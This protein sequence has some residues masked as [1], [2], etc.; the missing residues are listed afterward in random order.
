M[1]SSSTQEAR[2]MTV[3][4]KEKVST[5][6]KE[7][8]QKDVARQDRVKEIQMLEKKLQC[9]Q[10]GSLEKMLL[11]MR[12]DM[13]KDNMCMMEKIGSVTNVTAE[14]Q[15]E[16][17]SLKAEQSSMD[18]QIK[19]TQ[20][21]QEDEKVRVD[22]AEEQVQYLSEQVR[23]LHGLVCKQEQIQE[24]KRND[25]EQERMR[26]MSNNLLI[27]GLDEDD[28]E[29]STATAQLVTDFFSQ[30]MK[31][32]KPI[33]ICSAVCIGKSNSRNVLVKLYKVK[34][35]SDIFEKVSNLKD[36]RNS[37]D[38]KYYMNNH[39]TSVLQDQQRKYRQM[40]RYNALLTGTAKRHLQLKKGEL[41][42]DGHP[43]RPAV[44]APQAGEV[45]YPLD[46]KHVD[47]MKLIKG[48]VQKRGKCTF[49]GYAVEVANVADVRASYT[50]VKRLHPN[51]LHVAC[52]YRLPGIDYV[53]LRGYEDDGE[54]R[55]GRTIY[56]VMDNMNTFNKAI[57]VVRFHGNKHLGP[58]HFQLI[59]AVAKTVITRA[60]QQVNSTTQGC[61]KNANQTGTLI[62]GD[63][64]SQR[65]NQ[66]YVQATLPRPFVTQ[67]NKSTWGSRESLLS[68]TTGTQASP[69]CPRSNSLDSY[70]SL[71]SF[72]SAKQGM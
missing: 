18:L 71:S 13:K 46:Q 6:S 67:S 72:T 2:R 32:T 54:H 41:L 65:R 23:V 12:L 68:A 24:I 70:A 47:R 28:E 50:K 56:G 36:V 55:A 53:T 25:V 17:K 7:I 16:V 61:W 48:D 5:P 8:T 19:F 38:G 43:Y 57:F 4:T 29:M 15:N 51:A 31:I 34:D 69:T 59:T 62:M 63:T 9:M 44:V 64:G 49:I 66:A 3:I 52:A 22:R 14:L 30:T 11:E 42:V 33:T 35:K 45:V 26:E 21:V 37:N 27:T 39:L 1:E 20:G 40:I 58:V 10:E 60:N